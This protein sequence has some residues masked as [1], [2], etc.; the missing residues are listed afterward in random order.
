MNPKYAQYT[1]QGVEVIHKYSGS[2]HGYSYK[3]GDKAIIEKHYKDD[4]G[5][6]WINPKGYSI[7]VWHI[8]AFEPFVHK[9]LTR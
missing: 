8:N 3:K 5:T 2:G 4:D 1:M 6:I 9:I 7:D